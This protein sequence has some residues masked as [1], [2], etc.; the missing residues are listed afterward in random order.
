MTLRSHF[1]DPVFD[2]CS[3][4]KIL[5]AQ[6]GHQNTHKNPEHR[7]QQKTSSTPN[8]LTSKVM[9]GPLPLLNSRIPIPKLTLWEGLGHRWCCPGMRLWVGRWVRLS[10]KLKGVRWGP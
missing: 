9:L 4:I 7:Q 2:P 8:E 1:Q 3:G 10:L 5:Q 6:K